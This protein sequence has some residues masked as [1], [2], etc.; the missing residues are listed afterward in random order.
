MD[1][2]FLFSI[3]NHIF[4]FAILNGVVLVGLLLRSAKR[5]S[6]NYVLALWLGCLIVELSW[7][8]LKVGDFFYQNPDWI[9]AMLE[10]DALYGPLFFLYIVMQVKTY[11]L[12]WVH[13]F[14]LV[15][16]AVTVYVNIQAYF[17]SPELKL[18]QYDIYMKGE[19]ERPITAYELFYFMTPLISYV[20]AF[21]VI[22]GAIKAKVGLPRER[23]TWLYRFSV[24]QIVAWLM[25]LLI[26]SVALLISPHALTPAI[27]MASYLPYATVLY[28]LSGYS[29]W[30]GKLTANP[31]DKSKVNASPEKYQ[32]QKLSDEVAGTLKSKLITYMKS[33][34]P[35]LD[36]ELTLSDLSEKLGVS[37]HH[38]SQLLNQHFQQS[39]YDFINEY[40]IEEIKRRLSD[41]ADSN[42]TILS[43]ALGS[44]FNSK[45]TFNSVFKRKENMTPSAYRRQFSS[46][47]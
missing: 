4:I 34:R 5:N 30:Q 47:G 46:L 40:R 21:T 26:C 25:V 15:P 20:W 29:V 27:I 33:E 3:L 43:L 22:N 13:V 38:L 12:R 23:L 39:F 41:P 44:G 37:S 45:A 32:K 9:G 19:F 36:N 10:L 42:K 17:V 14:L 2:P 6:A 35:Y 31:F 7:N 1:A 18:L 11:Q 8:S 28:F 24:L 16:F